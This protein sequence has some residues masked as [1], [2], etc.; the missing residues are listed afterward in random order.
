MSAPDDSGISY[1]TAYA[2]R[3]GQILHLYK[4]EAFQKLSNYYNR[5]SMFNI[6][7]IERLENQHT[8]VLAW[9]LD[10]QESHGLDDYPLR[11]F[12][13]L[14]V[15]AKINYSANMNKMIGSKELETAIITGNYRLK[16]I[17]VYREY[18]FPGSDG[19]RTNK[20]RVDI[21][22]EADIYY[23]DTEESSPLR[24]LIE[25]KVNSS[26][27][28]RDHTQTETYYE[29]AN[30]QCEDAIL[31]FV[32]LKPKSYAGLADL[33]EPECAC[34]E[35]I[36]INY[37][38]LVDELIT[39]CLRRNIKNDAAVLLNDYMRCLSYPTIDSAKNDKGDT[40]GKVLIMAMGLEEKDL[41]LRLINENKSLIA[42]MARV[43]NDVEI[44]DETKKNIE[45]L[46][47]RTLGVSSKDSTSYSYRNNTYNKR[48]LVLQVM[49]DYINAHNEMTLDQ[50]RTAFKND[51]IVEDIQ[52]VKDTIRYFCQKENELN[53]SDG[54]IAVISNQWS[55]KPGK[56]DIND[57]IA[58]SR[59]LDIDIKIVE[60]R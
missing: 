41:L 43:V 22:I 11:N 7:G 26:E 52:K 4:S 3:A 47:D 55:C 58:A 24:I 57:F 29:L 2:E 6:T 9:L 51:R 1:D 40:E 21:W 36:Q 18:I 31:L 23:A 19:N 20:D 25:N 5:K 8:N 27:N 12:L 35:Y 34:K 54:T 53:L 42:A 60:K 59:E 39:P 15:I 50:I 48:K 10:D 49:T 32:Y 33:D 16:N 13:Q 45:A 38:L 44:D 37:D 56:G 30:D 14:L 17:Q 46:A 28:G